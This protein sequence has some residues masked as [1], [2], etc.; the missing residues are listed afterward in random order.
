MREEGEEQSDLKQAKT[1]L[2]GP[3]LKGTIKRA[4]DSVSEPRKVS[5]GLGA[6]QGIGPQRKPQESAFPG[7]SPEESYQDSH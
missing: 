6:A 7:R 4:T 5:K 2:Q 3:L 1:V